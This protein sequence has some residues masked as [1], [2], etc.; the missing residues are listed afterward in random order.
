V[1]ALVSLF[2]A[3]K[4]LLHAEAARAIGRDKDAVVS[5]AVEV[6]ARRASVDVGGGRGEGESGGDDS[7]APTTLQRLLMLGV[8]QREAPR[9][10]RERASQRWHLDESLVQHAV[11]WRG[12]FEVAKRAANAR[13][14]EELRLRALRAKRGDSRGAHASRAGKRRQQQQQQQQLRKE[15]AEPSRPESVVSAASAAV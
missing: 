7:A 5:D 8:E 4:A 15:G 13:L 12:E 14:V 3:T 9:P 6:A 2:H 1:E 11:R 10:R